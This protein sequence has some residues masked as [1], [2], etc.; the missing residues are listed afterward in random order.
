MREEF[1]LCEQPFE[2]RG[3]R[4]DEMI[5]VIR[6]LWGNGF[7]EHHGS[8]Y[9]FDRLEMSPSPPREIP[10][11]AGGVSEPALRR[12][13]QFCDGWISEIHGRDELRGYIERLRALRA[14]SPRRDRPFDVIAVCLEAG[15]VDAYRRLAEIGVTHVQ[16]QPWG[17]YGSTTEDLGERVRSIRRFGDEVIAAFA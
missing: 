10:I 6:T 3:A 13:A 15:D 1:T 5:E 14:G 2:Q 16:T 8:F 17:F 9:D 12:A 7:V 4:A 11:Y